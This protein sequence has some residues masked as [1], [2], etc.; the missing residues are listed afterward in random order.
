MLLALGMGFVMTRIII[1][2]VYIILITPIGLIRRV[3]GSETPKNIR[4][5]KKSDTESYWIARDDS[6]R[7]ESTERQF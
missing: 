2:L 4:N 6:Y 7:S 3:W 1:S 5:F